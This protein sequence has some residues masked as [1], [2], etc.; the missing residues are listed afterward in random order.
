MSQQSGGDAVPSITVNSPFKEINSSIS[1]SSDIYQVASYFQCGCGECN[2]DELTSCNC[3]TAIQEREYIQNQ[4]D[5]GKSVD[6]VRLLVFQTY[7]S[8]K[9]AHQDWAEEQLKKAIEMISSQ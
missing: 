6:D 1:A 5:R 9:P 3:P 7:G 2:D 8:I 4:L